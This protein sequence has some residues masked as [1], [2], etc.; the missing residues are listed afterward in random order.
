MIVCVRFRSEVPVLKQVPGNVL[1]M[2]YDASLHFK[3][4][5]ALLIAMVTLAYGAL[6]LC[7]LGSTKAPQQPWKSSDATEQV[8][9]DLG[10]RYEDFYMLYFA[11]VSYNDFTVEVS[12]D[13]M[14]WSEKCWAENG[15]RRLLSLDVPD[16]LHDGRKRKACL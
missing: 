3:R 12:D 13:G 9:L 4:L 7:N 5:D 6:A 10:E 2:R 11:P 8:V 1:N 15:T 14:V 16:N